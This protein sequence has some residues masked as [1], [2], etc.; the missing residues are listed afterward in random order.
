MQ[1]RYIE[2]MAFIIKDVLNGGDFQLQGVT[3]G[4][5]S[6]AHQRASWIAAAFINLAADYNPRFDRT[7]FLQ[8]CGLMEKPAKKGRAK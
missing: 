2:R 8:A 3:P 5:F 4:G 1:K 7:R 6:T